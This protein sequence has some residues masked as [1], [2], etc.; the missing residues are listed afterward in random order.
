M[1]FTVPIVL[2][3]IIIIIIIERV[4]LIVITV[5]NVA[6]ERLKKSR[7]EISLPEELYKQLQ[8]FILRRIPDISKENV[9]KKIMIIHIV[10]YE[11]ELRR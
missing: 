1:F 8:H 10:T 6:T 9:I 7:Q 2:L 3:I 11:H 5:T 4:V